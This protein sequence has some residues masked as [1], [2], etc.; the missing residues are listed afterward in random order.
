MNFGDR[1]SGKVCRSRPHL[2]HRYSVFVTDSVIVVVL[3]LPC[4]HVFPVGR[5]R[6]VVTSDETATWLVA[7]KARVGDEVAIFEG[8]MKVVFGDTETDGSTATV[9]VTAFSAHGRSVGATSTPSADTTE[10][11]A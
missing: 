9:E 2:C 1:A 8:V 11:S 3:V 4:R 5:S 6:I 10:A 7:S